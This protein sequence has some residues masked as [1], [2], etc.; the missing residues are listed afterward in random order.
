VRYLPRE[1]HLLL[2]AF[3][4]GRATYLDVCAHH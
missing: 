4:G 1:Q 3:L 2:Y